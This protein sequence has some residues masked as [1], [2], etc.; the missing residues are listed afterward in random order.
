M[1]AAKLP[2]GE[3][4]RTADDQKILAPSTSIVQLQV[5][6]ENTRQEKNE[7]RIN[8]HSNVLEGVNTLA[9]QSTIVSIQIASP[10]NCQSC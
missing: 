4:N 8:P 3:V 5:N 9:N 7:R 2:A 6:M 10:C 1:Y